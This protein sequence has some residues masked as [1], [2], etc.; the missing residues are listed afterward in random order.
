MTKFS[1]TLEE[2]TKDELMEFVLTVSEALID[3][4]EC[5]HEEGCHDHD[6]CES[7]DGGCVGDTSERPYCRCPLGPC[8]EA[9]EVFPWDEHAKFVELIILAR[10]LAGWPEP[11]DHLHSTPEQRKRHGELR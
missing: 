4:L 2:R 7:V 3:G 6:N 8:C 9:L 10:W 1:E 5:L 11:V